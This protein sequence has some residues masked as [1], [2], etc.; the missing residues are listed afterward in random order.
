M[1]RKDEGNIRKRKGPT[2]AR[3]KDGKALEPEASSSG[4]GGKKDRKENFHKRK[5]N[6]RRSACTVCC[7][8]RQKYILWPLSLK[9]GDTQMSPPPPFYCWWKRASSLSLIESGPKGNAVFHHLCITYIVSLRQL[10]FSIRS[11]TQQEDNY[12]KKYCNC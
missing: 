6:R 8:P 4:S 9:K 2:R 10:S 3:R 1:G 12:S 7:H 11:V 5:I